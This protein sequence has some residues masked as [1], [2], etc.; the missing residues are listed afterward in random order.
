MERDILHPPFFQGGVG[1][2]KDFVT[3]GLPAKKEPDAPRTHTL[4]GQTETM[5]DEAKDR[6]TTD[7]WDIM[8]EK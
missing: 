7:G 1:S 2:I 4:F 5:V 3:S 8:L 6:V